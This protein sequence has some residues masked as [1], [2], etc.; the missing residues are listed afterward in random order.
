MGVI[1]QGPPPSVNKERIIS[2]GG[3]N[4]CSQLRSLPDEKLQ[5]FI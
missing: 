5:L 3:E 2:Q 1:K 4:I